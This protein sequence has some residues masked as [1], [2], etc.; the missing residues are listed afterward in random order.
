MTWKLDDVAV[1]DFIETQ[2]V[3]RN[4]NHPLHGGRVSGIIKEIVPEYNMV[5][6]TSG[7]CCHTK[8]ILI[9]HEKQEP[10]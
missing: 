8:D 2:I 5:R 10:R 9:R 7:W 4:R 6:L 1:G 3:S